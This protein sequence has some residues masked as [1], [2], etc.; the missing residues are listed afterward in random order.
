M[1]PHQIKDIRAM[2]ENIRAEELNAKR[3]VTAP[4]HWMLAAIEDALCA[5]DDEN[6]G[7]WD[8]EG[9]ISAVTAYQ[10]SA[11]D[12]CVGEI[13]SLLTEGTEVTKICLR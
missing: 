4:N 5:L 13:E 7:K 9:Y 12:E 6:I 1:S 3:T 8:M 2:L 10:N 11:T